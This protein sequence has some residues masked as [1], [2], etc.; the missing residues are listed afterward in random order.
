MGT[1]ARRFVADGMY[2]VICAP[3]PIG[4]LLAIDALAYLVD[5][6]TNFLAPFLAPGVAAHKRP[7]V[8]VVAPSTARPADPE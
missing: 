6:C 7:R 1:T 8:T 3:R 2:W 5:G 4:V